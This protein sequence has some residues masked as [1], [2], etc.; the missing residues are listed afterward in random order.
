[1]TAETSDR[2][3]ETEVLS[4]RERHRAVHHG[5]RSRSEQDHE[6]EGER[7]GDAGQDDQ[8]DDRSEQ[9][10][11]HDEAPRLVVEIRRGDPE[12]GAQPHPLTPD[13]A[14]PATK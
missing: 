11:E 14:T 8:D 13:A 12:R 5:Q 7:R 10:V 4:L 6:R 1:M 2:F 9:Q 3:A